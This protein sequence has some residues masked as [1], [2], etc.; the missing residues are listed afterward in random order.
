MGSRGDAVAVRPFLLDVTA[1]TVAAYQACVEAAKCKPPNGDGNCNWGKLDRANHPANCVDWNQATA[2]CEA[3]GKRLPSEEEREWA[4]R[5]A[6]R[7]T[8]YPWGSEVRT[9]PNSDAA[10]KRFKKKT[11]SA[12]DRLKRHESALSGRLCGGGGQ[13]QTC[14]VGSYPAGDSPQGLKDL[15]GNVWEWTSSTWGESRAVRGGSWSTD[16]PSCYAASFRY[17]IDPQSRYN[18]LGF[19][20]AKTP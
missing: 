18:N 16:D 17:R 6:E 9:T 4:A 8:E 11:L 20:C 13:D 5:G 1:V 15:A 12:E 7:G 3:V 2:F 14:P 19:R 10:P